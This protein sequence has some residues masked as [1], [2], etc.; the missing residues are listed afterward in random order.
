MNKFAYIALVFGIAE[1]HKLS[2]SEFMTD[3]QYA[4]FHAK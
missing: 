4:A 2:K 1:A 3:E